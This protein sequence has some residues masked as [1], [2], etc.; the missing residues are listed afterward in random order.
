MI[1][2]IVKRE[3]EQLQRKGKTANI[4]VIGSIS[5]EVDLGNGESFDHSLVQLFHCANHKTN[6]FGQSPVYS[7]GVVP[8]NSVLQVTLEG[9]L[10]VI[11]NK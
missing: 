5:S 9:K 11:V 6:A 10:I 7:N 2:V 4:K 1:I 3:P 8:L